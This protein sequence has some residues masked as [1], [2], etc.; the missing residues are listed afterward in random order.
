MLSMLKWIL[1]AWLFIM[2]IRNSIIGPGS[3]VESGKKADL[4][5]LTSSIQVTGSL[6]EGNGISPQIL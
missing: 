2:G 1:L 3:G 6:L 4:L 5:T